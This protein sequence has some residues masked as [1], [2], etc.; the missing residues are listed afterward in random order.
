MAFVF[1]ILSYLFSRFFLLIFAF[2]CYKLLVLHYESQEYDIFKWKKKSKQKWFIC[3]E[4][5]RN[6]F[7]YLMVY[8]TGRELVG[9][10]VIYATR[11]INT[12]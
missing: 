9:V 4:I 12:L 2:S 11:A 7:V 5:C 10:I 3:W 8:N 6:N 1:A